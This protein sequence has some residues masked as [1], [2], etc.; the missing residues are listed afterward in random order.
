MCELILIVFIGSSTRTASRV[1]RCWGSTVLELD[2]LLCLC[3]APGS[4]NCSIGTKRS[5]RRD[6]GCPACGSWWTC[7]WSGYHRISASYKKNKFDAEGFDAQHW[8]LGITRTLPTALSWS[9]T[10]GRHRWEHQ[11]RSRTFATATRRFWSKR[12]L[13][14]GD[15]SI[16][17]FTNLNHTPF[18]GDIEN[19]KGEKLP[20]EKPWWLVRVV[21]PNIRAEIQRFPGR[22]W[23]ETW[24]DLTWSNRPS[25]SCG[26]WMSPFGPPIGRLGPKSR[27]K[28]R[29]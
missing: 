18:V 27:R 28:Y 5:L 14:H 6:V 2:D 1:W 11:G 17:L 13:E 4:T 19:W 25:P 15:T 10:V 12:F 23:L 29:R 20:K 21:P 3:S 7:C 9:N 26:S 8:K 16:G 24:A 22:A